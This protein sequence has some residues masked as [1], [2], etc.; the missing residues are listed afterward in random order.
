[1]ALEWQSRAFLIRPLSGRAREMLC[2]ICLKWFRGSPRT[3]EGI[4]RP[5][6][7]LSVIGGCVV[8]DYTVVYVDPLAWSLIRLA[9]GSAACFS[10]VS[11]AGVSAERACSNISGR[12]C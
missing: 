1:M 7:L 6:S 11:F 12:C 2:L 8:E 4:F 5:T 3:S 10:A 9:R